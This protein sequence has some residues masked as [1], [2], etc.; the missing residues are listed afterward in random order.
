MLDKLGLHY[1]VVLKC[2]A[3]IGD[4][5]ARGVDIDCWLPGQDTYRE[6][7]SAD[8]MT[9]FQARGLKSRYRPNSGEIS[10][11]HTNDAT[12]FAMGRTLAAIT[13]QFQ[14]KEGNITVPEVLRPY[15]GG[16]EQL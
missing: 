8:Y 10:F 15:I 4:P 16:R 7:H 12:A 14:T 1:R 13:E 6:T 11:L 5:N 3:D 9:D 2:T